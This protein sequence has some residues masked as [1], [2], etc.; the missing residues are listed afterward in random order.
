MK[1]LKKA[2]NNNSNALKTETGGEGTGTNISGFSALLAG[3]RSDSFKWLG[4]NTHFW[5]STENN[6]TNANNMNLWNNDS[7]INFNNNNKENGFSVRCLK[8]SP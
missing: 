1:K 8:D 6:A 3:Y 5:S 4:T 2:V 7:N